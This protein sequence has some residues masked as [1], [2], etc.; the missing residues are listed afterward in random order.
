MS[1]KKGLKEFCEVYDTV[2]ELGWDLLDLAQNLCFKFEY[3]CP[4]HN[5]VEKD[6]VRLAYAFTNSALMERVHNLAK[7]LGYT[8]EDYI[9]G[10]DKRRGR[11]NCNIYLVGES[12]TT[13]NVADIIKEV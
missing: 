8:R 1:K 13:C 7:A 12:S 10:A 9:E 4:E 3:A 2:G 6:D 5:K 11:G